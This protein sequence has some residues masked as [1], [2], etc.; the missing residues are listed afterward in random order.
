MG[1]QQIQVSDG[2]LIAS[3]GNPVAV[4]QAYQDHDHTQ[5]SQAEQPYAGRQAQGQQFL[6]TLATI[7]VDTL[8]NAE[9]IALFKLLVKYL[10]ARMLHEGK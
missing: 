2:H 4:V 9:L 7:D 1:A 10:Q 6:D 5:T 8:T 3:T